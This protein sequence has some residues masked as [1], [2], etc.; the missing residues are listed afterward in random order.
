MKIEITKVPK[1]KSPLDVLSE[2]GEQISKSW[3]Y[4]HE[5]AYLSLIRSKGVTTYTK[6]EINGTRTTVMVWENAKKNL[7]IVVHCEEPIITRWG[8]IS[9]IMDK[10]I[11]FENCPEDPESIFFLKMEE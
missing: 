7:R 5:N 3:I 6:P 8:R 11:S 2:M 10:H 1:G 9:F 4:L